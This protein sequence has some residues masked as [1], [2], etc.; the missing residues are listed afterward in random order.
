MRQVLGNPEEPRKRLA[1]KNKTPRLESGRIFLRHQ[2]YQGHTALVKDNVGNGAAG[3]QG[4]YLQ[5][6]SKGGFQGLYLQTL[7]KGGFQGL[8]L[9]T[10]TKE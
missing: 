1:P 7:R 9:Q 8:Y 5:T 2:F 3:F 4:L 6:L 10:L